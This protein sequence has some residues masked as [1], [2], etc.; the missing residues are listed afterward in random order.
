MTTTIVGM[1]AA[2]L[3]DPW[4]R[5]STVDDARLESH[6]AIAA[7]VL[8]VLAALLGIAATN[9]F[10]RRLDDRLRPPAPGQS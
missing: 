9:L 2:V 3:S 1:T 7:T 5:P 10:T 4:V 8:L 6:L